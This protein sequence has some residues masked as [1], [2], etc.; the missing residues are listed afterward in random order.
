ME[1]EGGKNSIGV[2]HIVNFTVASAFEKLADPTN[3]NIPNDKIYSGSYFVTS[4][5]H[6]IGLTTYTKELELAR[7]T[8]PYD[9]N[10]G[11]TAPFLPGQSL[12]RRYKDNTNSTTIV[13]KYWRKGLV[14]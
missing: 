13:N 6:K 12:N 10:T 14:P 2:G 8:V 4:V 11:V 3:A 9:F 1:I 5:Q 7:S